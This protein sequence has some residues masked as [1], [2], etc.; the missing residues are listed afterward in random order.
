MVFRNHGVLEVWDAETA[1]IAD[2]T[3][4]RRFAIATVHE[5]PGDTANARLIAAAPRL[6]SAVKATLGR[7]GDWIKDFGANPA[8]DT[9]APGDGAA[10]EIAA[11]V[12]ME[13]MQIL[14]AAEAE[15]TPD[16]AA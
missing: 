3:S 16:A 1:S 6:R 10:G 2:K 8:T 13:M 15:L 11:L 14:A 12:L 4:P 9:S 7:G 5:R